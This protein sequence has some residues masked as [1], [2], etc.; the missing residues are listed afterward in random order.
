[1]GKYDYLPQVLHELGIEVVFHKIT[2]RPGLP[3]W[4]GTSKAGQPV[5]ALPGNPVSALVCLTRYVL[6][7]LGQSLQ[8]VAQNEYV[9]LAE[10]LD[11]AAELSWFVPVTVSYADD[12]RG[13]AKPKLTNTSGDFTALSG[14]TGFIELPHEQSHFP[15]GYVARLFRW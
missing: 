8:K 10:P 1:M 13:M 14:T 6:P 4:F 2:Q 5:F 11:F 3:M 12:G 15:L 7:A 9:T